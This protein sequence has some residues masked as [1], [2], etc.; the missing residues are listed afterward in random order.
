[1]G[2]L[3][4]AC[5]GCGKRL[6]KGQVVCVSCGYHV[7][8]DRKLD[9]KVTKVKERVLARRAKRRAASIGVRLI[10]HG[11]TLAQTGVLVLVAAAGRSD[12]ESLA[13]ALDILQGYLAL[14]GVVI[15]AY[16]VSQAG[17]Y[18]LVS[19]FVVWWVL[20]ADDANPYVM[21]V[22]FNMFVSVVLI[23]LSLAGS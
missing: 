7:A 18:A 21:G 11:V 1:M 2:T 15:L 22:L 8:D 14:G 17:L 3:A 23:M 6:T 19:N 20:M 5:P 4:Q 10:P 12:P 9:T 13:M 16:A